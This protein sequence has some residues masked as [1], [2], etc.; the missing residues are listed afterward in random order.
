MLTVCCYSPI[1]QEVV[2]TGDDSTTGTI[3][4][5]VNG[6]ACSRNRCLKAKENE[7]PIHWDRCKGRMVFSMLSGSGVNRPTAKRNPTV[8]KNGTWRGRLFD[9]TRQGRV[10]N[11]CVVDTYSVYHACCLV[12]RAHALH[13]F[14]FRHHHL[15]RFPWESLLSSSL[16]G[17]CPAWAVMILLCHCH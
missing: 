4:S 14:L 2:G 11:I 16:H 12:K 8:Q 3:R 17:C 13:F 10:S 9:G 1:D 15:V 5:R 7:M 6:L